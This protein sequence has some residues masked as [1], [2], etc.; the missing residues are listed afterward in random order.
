MKPL[1]ED[2][3]AEG[4]PG[5]KIITQQGVVA[6]GV[7]GGVNRQPTFGHV[8]FAIQFGLPVLRGNE[9]RA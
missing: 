8:D 4:L 7:T 5:V 1:Q 3:P 6:G 2:Q 9:L